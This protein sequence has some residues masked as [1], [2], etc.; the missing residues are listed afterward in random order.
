MSLWDRA[1]ARVF[2]TR[3][4][5]GACKFYSGMGVSPLFFN[6]K[7]MGETPMPLEIQGLSE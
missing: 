1:T 6:E 7:R 5:L 2:D 3:V 4:S